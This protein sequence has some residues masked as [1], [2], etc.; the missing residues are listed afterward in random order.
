VLLLKFFLILGTISKFVYL[1][2]YCPTSC[3]NQF[4]WILYSWVCALWI[5]FNNCP[6][7]CDCIQFIIFL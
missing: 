3:W 1:R 7:R 6:T 2:M 5:K 4:C